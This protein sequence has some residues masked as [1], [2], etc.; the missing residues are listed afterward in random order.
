MHHIQNADDHIDRGCFNVHF[1]HGAPNLDTIDA[2]ANDAVVTMIPAVTSMMNHS[3]TAR[4]F[5]RGVDAV[6]IFSNNKVKWTSSTM[7][8]C[9]RDTVTGYRRNMSALSH[10]LSYTVCIIHYVKAGI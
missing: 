10:G 2:D 5:W 6:M 9:G 7:C 1:H 4:A 3:A 8:Q